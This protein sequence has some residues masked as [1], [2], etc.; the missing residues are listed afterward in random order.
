MA[1]VTGCGQMAFGEMA[2]TP[3][4]ERMNAARESN[5]N[6]RSMSLSSGIS[7][8]GAMSVQIAFK[9]ESISRC[10]PA[11]RMLWA[12]EDFVDDVDKVS[13]LATHLL[14]VQQWYEFIADCSHPRNSL[15]T[16]PKGRML[17]L[18]RFPEHGYTSPGNS[19]RP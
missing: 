13:G 11:A 12:I 1:P 2:A 7:G 17:H 18:R 6:K 5:R 3:D 15:L 16:P 10:R 14:N 9:T 19:P 8:R 4:H